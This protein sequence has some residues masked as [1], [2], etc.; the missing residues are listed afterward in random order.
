MEQV[1]LG[2]ISVSFQNIE[3]YTSLEAI[4]IIVQGRCFTWA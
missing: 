4:I 1:D 2:E 3:H